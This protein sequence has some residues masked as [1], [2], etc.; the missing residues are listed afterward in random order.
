MKRILFFF[1]F[2]IVSI[3]IY[4]QETR[5]KNRAKDSLTIVNDS[6]YKYCTVYE[7]AGASR[8]SLGTGTLWCVTGKKTNKVLTFEQ[9][10]NWLSV[11]GWEVVTSFSPAR[12]NSYIILRKKVPRQQLIEEVEN[13]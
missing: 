9:L 3:T 7:G 10:L 1:V 13:Y 6:V 2:W 11:D 4:A 8:Y 12:D 5:S